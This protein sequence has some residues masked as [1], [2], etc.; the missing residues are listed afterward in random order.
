MLQCLDAFLALDDPLEAAHHADESAAPLAGISFRRALFLSARAADHRIL[1]VEVRHSESPG[2]EKVKAQLPRRL[3]LNLRGVSRASD[4]TRTRLDTCLRSV[5]RIEAILNL[6]S[7]IVAE[8]IGVHEAQ[9][10]A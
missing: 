4:V 3:L 6:Q 2:T 1:L 8:I 10:R 7:E 5:D 9:T